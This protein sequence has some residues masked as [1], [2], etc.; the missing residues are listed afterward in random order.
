LRQALS[1]G[2]TSGKPLLKFSIA[3]EVTA[4]AFEMHPKHMLPFF[5]VKNLLRVSFQMLGELPKG[6]DEGLDVDAAA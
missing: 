4:S 1:Q 5:P 2:A 6:N 3:D